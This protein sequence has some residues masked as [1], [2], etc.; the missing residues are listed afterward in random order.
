MVLRDDLWAELKAELARTE[1]RI[2]RLHVANV[3]A[4]FS[5]ASKQLFEHKQF[6]LLMMERLATGKPEASTAYERIMSE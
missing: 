5:T 3:A 4:T 6:V 1:A 2:D